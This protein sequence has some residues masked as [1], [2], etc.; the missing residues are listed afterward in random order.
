MD[1]AHRMARS[2]ESLDVDRR[3]ARTARSRPIAESRV[4]FIEYPT[5]NFSA[6]LKSSCTMR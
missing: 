6:S 3:G 1:M 5:F 4:G 2:I